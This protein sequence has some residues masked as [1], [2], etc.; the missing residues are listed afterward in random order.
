[1]GSIESEAKL[2]FKFNIIKSHTNVLVDFSS[3]AKPRLKQNY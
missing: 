3:S 1:M 2:L